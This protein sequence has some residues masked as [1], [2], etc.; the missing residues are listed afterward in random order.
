MQSPTAFALLQNFPNPFNPETWI[1][2][3]LAEDADVTIRIF[4]IR[5]KQI[6]TVHLG[7]MSV[8]YY[9]SKGKAAF[10]DGRDCHGQEVSSGIYFYN[11][12]AGSFSATRKLTI[13][14]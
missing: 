13:I 3:H 2:F 7:Q 4:D 6:R 8:G 14:K 5:G 12:T 9:N 1:P 10:W 11:I